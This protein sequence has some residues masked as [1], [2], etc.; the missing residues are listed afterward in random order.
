MIVTPLCITPLPVII[1]VPL[2]MF[3]MVEGNSNSFGE[4]VVRPK[5][6]FKVQ[7]E[8]EFEGTRIYTIKYR[9]CYLQYH[10]CEASFEVVIKFDC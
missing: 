9:C 10:N 3:V 7:V 4:C 1:H 8:T 5:A 2:R 6:R